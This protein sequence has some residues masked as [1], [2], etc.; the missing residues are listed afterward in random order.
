MS[1][2]LG[3]ITSTRTQS[4]PNRKLAPS[5]AKLWSNITD[6]FDISDAPGIEMLTLACQA[7][8]R[9]ESLREKIDRDG[10]IVETEKG[11]REHPCL[12]SELQNR[13]FVV[14]TLQ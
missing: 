4:K 7:L 10:E 5:G 14:R 12:K 13:S 1:A 3:L 8:D 11:Q 6:E 2:K 9:A